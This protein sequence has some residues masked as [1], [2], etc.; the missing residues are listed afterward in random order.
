MEKSTKIA[1]VIEL[2]KD[3]V[4]LLVEDSKKIRV[5]Y[6]YFDIYP[7]IGDKVKVYQDD[8]NFIILLD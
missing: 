4:V 7:I 1:K 5:P 3:N 8:E 2:E 6:D